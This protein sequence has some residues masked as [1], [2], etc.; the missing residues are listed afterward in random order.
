MMMKIIIII[1]IIIVIIMSD[2]EVFLDLL[3]AFL[4]SDC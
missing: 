3:S 4:H 1:I 2:C